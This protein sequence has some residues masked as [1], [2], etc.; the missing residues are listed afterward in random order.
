MPT[1]FSTGTEEEGK[2][3]FLVS[4]YFILKILLL[5]I[6]FS[7]LIVLFSHVLSYWL[8]REF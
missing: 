6:D 3:K 1:A 2:N 5:V 7:D 8:S 4:P